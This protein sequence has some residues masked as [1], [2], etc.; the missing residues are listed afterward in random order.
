MSRAL[1]S[2]RARRAN[3]TSTD[4]MSANSSQRSSGLESNQTAP[5]GLTLPQV[6]ALVDTR[7]VTLEKFMKYSQQNPQKNVR[8]E[9]PQQRVEGTPQNSVFDSQSQDQYEFET[10]I[11]EVLEDFNNRFTVLANEIAELKDIVL[12]LQSYT[13]DVNKTLMQDRV[14]I[15][16]DL[17]NS[18]ESLFVMKD[19]S[20]DISIEN[21]LESNENTRF[22]FSE[23]N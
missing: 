6:I 1:A 10:P 15:L 13:M 3:V 2:A 21:V 17:G 4:P 7:L 11:V 20:E 8:F 12:K 22:S 19:S 18:E 23:S 16:S 9:E 14:R 5:A